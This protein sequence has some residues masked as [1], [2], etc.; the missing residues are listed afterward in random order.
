M[1]ITTGTTNIY[2]HIAEKEGQ[3]A[4]DWENDVLVMALT[5][6]YTPDQDHSVVA[7]MTNEVAVGGYARYT[8]QNV[9]WT[10]VASA[11]SMLDFDDAVF[12]AT[13]ADFTAEHW[14]VINYTRSS[15][16]C[17]VGYLDNTPATVVVT[18]GNTMTV[19]PNANGI[20]R[21]TMP[22]TL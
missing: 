3:A 5:N 18:D 10:M 17:F 6:G 11:I 12:T 1:A 15:A 8:L 20:F 7:Q 2:G 14:H 16:L 13:G 21:K 22:W 4:W 9:N 19:Q